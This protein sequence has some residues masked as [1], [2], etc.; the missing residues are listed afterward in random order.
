MTTREFLNAVITSNISEEMNTKA[1]ALI[2]ALDKKN[3]QRKAKP[4]KTAI[5]NEPVKQAIVDTYKG[6]G[7][8]TASEVCV[9]MGMTV[10]KASA[11]LR[12]IA[13]EGNALTSEVKVKGKGKVK[14]YTI[15]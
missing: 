11:L 6:K 5:A 14:A 1:Q 8:V 12:Q 7:A 13:E 4:S 15:Q 3:S 2:V 9:A 10:Q